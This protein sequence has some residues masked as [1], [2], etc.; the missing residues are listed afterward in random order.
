MFLRCL[1]FEFE[2]EEGEE[3]RD[4]I[5]PDEDSPADKNTPGS[6]VRRN[7]APSGSLGDRP[8]MDAL[9]NIL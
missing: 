3:E 4:L 6:D 7:Y 5:V 9:T 2:S 8:P 1:Y